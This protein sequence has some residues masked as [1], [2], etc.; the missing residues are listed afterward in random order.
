MTGQHRGYGV[1]QLTVKE[2][3]LKEHDERLHQDRFD[4]VRPVALLDGLEHDLQSGE[5]A[6]DEQDE[7]DEEN[8]LQVGAPPTPHE[9]GGDIRDGGV[10]GDAENPPLE[11]TPSDGEDDGDP[12]NARP[13]R[14]LG[15]LFE[16]GKGERDEFND[17]EVH[18]S[19]QNADEPPHKP[20]CHK[21]GSDDSSP[22]HADRATT[23][24]PG[25]EHHRDKLVPPPAKRQGVDG[26]HRTP[27][28]GNDVQGREEEK[29]KFQGGLR[30]GGVIPDEP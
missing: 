2:E 3:D 26:G 14:L 21:H 6:S 12:G 28:A 23:I 30:G 13:Q 9:V 27:H 22:V 19:G 4:Y 7:E 25:A 29:H 11:D 24:P 16:E 18:A 5:T 8:R 17:A 20:R 1:D 15:D 10:Q